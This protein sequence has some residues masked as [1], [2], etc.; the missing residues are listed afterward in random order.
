MNKKRIAAHEKLPIRGYLESWEFADIINGIFDDIG[1]CKDCTFYMTGH[2][3]EKI[4]Q[5]DAEL[6]ETSWEDLDK[7]F[8]VEE[9]HYCGNFVRT[10]SENEETTD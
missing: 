5:R 2:C 4:S 7:Y 9:T 10:G 6:F 8:G 1:Q 3:Y